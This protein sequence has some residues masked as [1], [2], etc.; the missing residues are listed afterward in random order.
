MIAGNDAFR[1]ENIKFALKLMKNGV[2]VDIKELKLLPHGFLSYN[3]PV[4]GMSESSR[5]I[6]LGTDLLKRLLA[7]EPQSPTW[8]SAQFTAA[9][10]DIEKKVGAATNG[11]R[12]SFEDQD[13]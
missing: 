7:A 4:F 11:R 5:A 9:P 8:N 13:Y 6:E 1:D 12:L 3:F 2:S 10:F